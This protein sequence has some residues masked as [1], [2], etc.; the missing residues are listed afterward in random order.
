MYV[1]FGVCAEHEWLALLSSRYEAY[2][3]FHKVMSKGY[4]F[5]PQY[6]SIWSP[7]KGYFSHLEYTDIFH[8]SCLETD[9]T[10][11]FFSTGVEK[12]RS[13][14]FK[15]IVFFNLE[16]LGKIIWTFGELRDFNEF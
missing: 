2:Y 13:K 11:F 5:F 3:V 1:I 10:D 6:Y 12:K 15:N 4:R 7:T 16:Y 14:K 8:P 9:F